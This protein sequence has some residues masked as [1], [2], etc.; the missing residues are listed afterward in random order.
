MNKINVKDSSILSLDD[1]DEFYKNNEITNH[2]K[3]TSLWFSIRA[4]AH[5][6]LELRRMLEE[7]VVYYKLITDAPTTTNKDA[8]AFYAP[9]IPI[10]H[11]VIS[12]T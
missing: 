5:T 4:A 7:I 10:I 6:N 9:Y 11:S 8:A 12:D 1:Y 3:N 2:P